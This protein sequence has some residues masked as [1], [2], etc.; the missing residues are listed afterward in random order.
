MVEGVDGGGGG[1]GVE[2]G[3]GYGG[4]DGGAGGGDGGG[5]MY[6]A[7]QS[8]QSVPRSHWL[9]SASAPPSWQRLLLT[10]FEPLFPKDLVQVFSQ[11]IGGGDAGEGGGKL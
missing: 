8:V 3:G 5:D 4:D 6:R 7:P 11:R 10:N 1:G 9:P 2:G